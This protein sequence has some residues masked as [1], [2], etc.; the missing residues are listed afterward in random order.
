MENFPENSL[1]P[2]GEAPLIP[3]EL[4]WLSFNERVLQEAENK[5]V[6]VIERIRYLGIFS[7]NLDEFFRVRVANVRRLLAFSS[8][9]EKEKAAQL[10]DDIQQRVVQLQ[11]RFDLAY[12]DSLGELEKHDIRLIDEAQVQTQ[13]R[14]FLRNYFEKKILPILRPIVFTDNQTRIPQLSDSSIYFAVK[15][16]LEN[17]QT[18]YSLLEIPSPPLS[19]FVV[20]P[21][22]K[23]SKQKEIIVLE[24]IIRLYLKEVFRHVFAIQSAE[25]YTFKLTRDAEL[26]FSESISQ[27][28]IDKMA[29]SLKKRKWADPVRFVYDRNI[30]D[31]LLVFLTKNL[32]FGRYDSI[33]PG[34]RYHNFKDFIQFPNLGPAA[35]EYKKIAP[36]PLKRLDQACSVFDTLQQG[37]VLLYYPYHAFIY[38]ENLL[39]SAA[40]DP[41]VRT[42]QITLYRLAGD[43]HVANALINAAHNQKDVTVIMELQARFDEQANIQWANQLSDAGIKVIFGVPGLK[44]HSKLIL[45]S[46]MEGH[47]LRHYSHIGTGNFNEK[48]ARIYTDFALLTANQEIG[49]EVANVFDFI[50]YTYRRFNYRHLLVSPHTFR[51][52][53]TQK[54][55]QEI[56]HA[57]A[58]KKAGI[59]FKCNNLVDTAII[60]ALYDASR[61]GVK[62]RLIIRGMMS[63]VPG[64]V[65]MSDNI[66]AISIVD[67]YLEHARVY[68]FEN[69]DQPLYYLA[70]ADLMTRNL[71]GRVEVACPIYDRRLQTFL[72]EII[73]LQWKDHSKARIL[74]A[75]QQNQPRDTNKKRELRAQVDTFPLVMRYSSQLD[76]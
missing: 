26:E 37:D 3:K 15:L 40:L 32:G 50:R 27:S 38:V 73:E 33:M 58:G 25:A 9:K 52:S 10:Y 31:D 65:G 4:S 71:D 7:N 35:L 39:Y 47:T 69:D 21:P 67:R 75:A 5:T 2:L 6:P 49:Q 53:I 56:Q 76:I 22:P 64:I 70:S 34:S 1:V 59:T 24:N 20:I 30:P 8:G 68:I 61:A 63:L 18:R 46:R 16:N 19:R 43:S 57:K 66:E 44:V 45:I 72:R 28:L 54:I 62:I 60:H 41:C 17:N 51:S 23:H 14:A 42:I 11:Q 55:A 13:Q 29:S 36:I 74:D 12:N 48:T